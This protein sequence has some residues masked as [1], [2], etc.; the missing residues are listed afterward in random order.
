MCFQINIF[1]CRYAS[2]CST[3]RELVQNRVE[4]L[5]ISKTNPTNIGLHC[6]LKITWNESIH[7]IYLL[8]TILY[9]R[10]KQINALLLNVRTAETYTQFLFTC[11]IQNSLNCRKPFSPSW[12]GMQQNYHSIYNASTRQQNRQKFAKQYSIPPLYNYSKFNIEY[13]RMHKSSLIR[14]KWNYD[15]KHVSGQ[16]EIFTLDWCL[17]IY[18]RQVQSH[19]ADIRY[20]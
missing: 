7:R 10:K 16:W 13:Q 4:N 20:V 8:P 5:G 9:W 19:I 3:V 15:G 2:C 17:Q 18:T 14:L 6:L 12:W 1:T 11:N